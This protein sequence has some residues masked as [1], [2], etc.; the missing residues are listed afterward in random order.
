LECGALS[1]LF[2]DRKKTIRQ[3]W[4]LATT[5]ALS[6]LFL[7]TEKKQGRVALGGKKKSGDK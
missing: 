1:P 2:G 6:P 5:G 7:G 4:H 3:S